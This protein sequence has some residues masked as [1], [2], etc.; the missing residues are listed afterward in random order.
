MKEQGQA[1]ADLMGDLST[2]GR[3]KGRASAESVTGE[4]AGAGICVV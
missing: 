2:R 3:E 4:V 1:V